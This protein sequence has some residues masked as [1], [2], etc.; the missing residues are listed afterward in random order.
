[1]RGGAVGESKCGASAPDRAHPCKSA[2]SRR[3]ALAAVTTGSGDGSQS[4]TKRRQRVAGA[5]TP[6]R[7]REARLPS[8]SRKR[9]RPP[10]AQLPTEAPKSGPECR[11]PAATLQG[12]RSA[13]LRTS[14]RRAAFAGTDTAQSAGGG[15]LRHVSSTPSHSRGRTGTSANPSVTYLAFAPIPA[16]SVPLS[17]SSLPNAASTSSI[18]ARRASAALQPI[19][20]SRSKVLQRRYQPGAV[21]LC[22]GF[23]SPSRVTARA[24][25]KTGSKLGQDGP[26]TRSWPMKCRA[27]AGSSG[28]V[29]RLY[30]ALASFLRRT[31]AE[32]LIPR[33]HA[34]TRCDGAAHRLAK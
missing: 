2:R 31:P 8:L 20:T 22:R 1:M 34:R 27:V 16:T 10:A 15:F 14:L 33:H 4:P 12:Q 25:I 17:T 21:E 13:S 23:H 29:D 19:D 5:R 26:R 7:S 9:C 3:F 11:S 32:P 30:L 28:E 18:P 6:D 24:M